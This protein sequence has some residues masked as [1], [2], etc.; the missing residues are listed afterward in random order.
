MDIYDDGTASLNSLIYNNSQGQIN[1]T[2]TNLTTNISLGI[3]ETVFVQ[4]NLLGLVDDSDALSLNG[5]ARITFWGLDLSIEPDLLKNG[6]E[7][8]FSPDCEIIDWGSDY[9]V[10]DVNSFSNYSIDGQLG[11]QGEGDPPAAV[12]EFS[13]YAIMFL[14]V[15]VI[16][17]FVMI[18][19]RE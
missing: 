14:L 10:F 12:P 17:G 5:S 15:T 4:Q 9:A 11:G 7:Y 19:K 1:W 6:L 2:S 18:R 8:C 13:D 3:N 16:G